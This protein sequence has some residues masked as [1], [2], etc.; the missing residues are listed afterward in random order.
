MELFLDSSN[1]V[2]IKFNIYVPI[3]TLHETTINNRIFY[4]QEKAGE[5]I[6]KLKKRIGK[7][8]NKTDIIRQIIIIILI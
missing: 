1:F 3:M 5:N 8:Q 4:Q 7:S 6:R 2:V